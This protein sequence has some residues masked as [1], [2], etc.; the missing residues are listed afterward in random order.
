M[1]HNTRRSGGCSP[2]APVRPGRTG[3]NRPVPWPCARHRPPGCTAPYRPYIPRPGCGSAAH[4]CGEALPPP[5]GGQ[6]QARRRGRSARPAVPSSPGRSSASGSHR[7][8]CSWLH[9]GPRRCRWARWSQHPDRGS[10]LHSDRRT[11]FSA[12]IPA[13]AMRVL[14]PLFCLLILSRR[15]SASVSAPGRGSRTHTARWR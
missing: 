15:A 12:A 11:I 10:C 9:P 3:Q 5:G 14:S 8:E 6:G 2:P 4:S 7:P 1:H 13:A